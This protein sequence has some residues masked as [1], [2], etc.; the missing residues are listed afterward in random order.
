VRSYDAGKKIKGRKWHIAVESLGK[1]LT[2]VAHSADIQDRV[3]ARA[4]VTQS[5]C[6]FAQHRQGVCVKSSTDAPHGA[7]TSRF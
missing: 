2:V 7:S 5:F 4:V 3:G 6:R 1:L